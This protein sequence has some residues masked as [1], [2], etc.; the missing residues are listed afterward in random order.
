MGGEVLRLQ[1]PPIQAF[2]NPVGCLEANERVGHALKEGHHQGVSLPRRLH[3]YETWALY[4]RLAR[5]VERD[6]IRAG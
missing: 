5:R 3:V 6:F 4:I 1:L 2:Y